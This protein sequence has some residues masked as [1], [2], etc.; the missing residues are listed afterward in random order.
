MHN[1]SDGDD[2]NN[3]DNNYQNLYICTAYHDKI[4]QHVLH[5]TLQTTIKVRGS[6]HSIMYSDESASFV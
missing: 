6:K 5:Q 4:T 2:N 3:D 1:D